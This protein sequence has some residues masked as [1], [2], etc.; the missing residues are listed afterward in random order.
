MHL[1]A[2]AGK[3]TSLR[4]LPCVCS[5]FSESAGKSLLRCAYV[6]VHRVEGIAAH[7][8]A[9]GR[10]QTTSLRSLLGVCSTLLRGAGKSFVRCAD[11][12]VRC[13]CTVRKES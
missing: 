1:K 12:G 13:V 6:C 9:G 7:A 3:N 10:R 5:I 4:S 2:G 8:F 11:I